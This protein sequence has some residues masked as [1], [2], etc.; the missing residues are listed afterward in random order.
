MKTLSKSRFVSGIQCDKKI[1]FDFYRKDLKLPTDEQTQAVF[2]LGH[3]IGILAQN[4][5]PNGKDATPEDYSNL[6]PSIEN[7]QK[8]I[9]EKVETIYEA[10]FSA[11]NAFCMLDILHR[12]DEEVWAIEVKNSTSVKD[13]HLTDASLQYFVMKNAGF[14]PDRFFMM[15]I[16]N[17]Y[18]KQGELTSEIFALEDITEEVIANQD[19]V[20]ENLE[21]LLKMLEINEEPEVKIGGHCSDPFGCDYA[22]HCWK[23]IP[24]N[25]V[26]ELYRG[27]NKGWN[28]YEQNI[29][30]IDEIPDDFS[31]THFQNLQR[32]G[33]QN[34]ES[35]IDEI[36]IKNIISPWEFPLYFFDFETIFPAIPVLDGTRPYQQVPFQYSLHIL[37]EY[38]NL[39]HKEFLANPEDFSN[40][41][42]PLK[43]LVQQ[44][45]KDFGSKGNIVTYNQSFEILRLKELAQRF[46]ED[47]DFL[48]SLVERVVDLL[49]VFQGGYCYFPAMKNSAS[50]KAVLPA[51]APDFTYEN[52]E[53]QDGGAASSLFHQSIENGN[54]TDENLRENLLKY[55]ERDTLA[56]VVIYQF[57]M[58]NI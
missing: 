36:A 39:S 21:R 29:L 55:C 8:W 17:Q 9:Y 49:P 26:F 24:E 58:E 45:K 23:H 51:I 41:E 54:F 42:N 47:S 19:W 30:K 56:M 50:I 44:L 35:Y 57:L 33:L 13:Y 34:N 16:N 14:P 22:H 32:N 3:R 25:S 18:V 40:G 11:K 31:L 27:G 48:Y 38:G 6:K 43:H 46:P 10:T 7:T 28:L 37:D 4:M 2:D 1:W 12:K 15:H 20:A 5:F 53:V 52:L